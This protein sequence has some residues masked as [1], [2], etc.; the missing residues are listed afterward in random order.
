MNHYQLCE[1]NLLTYCFFEF[2]S[3]ICV[4][5]LSEK[6]SSRVLGKT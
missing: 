6:G 1:S 2:N 5:A 4:N 3:D